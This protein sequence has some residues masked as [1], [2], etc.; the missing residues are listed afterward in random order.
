LYVRFSF[1]VANYSR[2]AILTQVLQS[3]AKARGTVTLDVQF[4]RTLG[5]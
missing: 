1:F 2:A 5:P 3:T 4:V